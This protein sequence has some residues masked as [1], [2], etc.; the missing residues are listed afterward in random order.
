MKQ[1]LS[2]SK[3]WQS[4][5]FGTGWDYSQTFEIDQD[6]PLSDACVE[7]HDLAEGA[8]V[9]INGIELPMQSDASFD[10]HEAI[11][12]GHN[13]ITVRIAQE[14]QPLQICREARVISHDKVS[15]ASID[16]D[17]ETIDC[18]ANIWIR[19][20]VENHTD[21]EQDVLAS[22]VV[23]QGEN[24]EKVEIV[25]TI[26]TSGGEIEAVIRIM[27]PSMWQS[28]EDG[29]KSSFDC[30]VGL[31]VEDEIMDVADLTFEVA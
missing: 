24:R 2:L 27:D 22:I 29:T 19:I 12:T 4:R 3:I 26:P 25:E 20:D 18:I 21:E 17:P 30:M 31:Q 6:S 16:I 8:T 11:R 1:T 28:S 23:A 13:E 5:N 10:A 7:F 15:I 14:T 9:T